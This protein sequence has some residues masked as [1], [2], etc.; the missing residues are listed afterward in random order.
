V[1]QPRKFRSLDEATVDIAR[2]LEKNGNSIHALLDR[3]REPREHIHHPDE[4][5]EY[6]NDTFQFFDRKIFLNQLQGHVRPTFESRGILFTE[7]AGKTITISGKVYCAKI[8]LNRRLFTEALRRFGRSFTQDHLFATLLHQMIHA[9]FIAACGLQNDGKD[10]DGR[11]KHEEHFG[12]IM[13]RIREISGPIKHLPIGF[14]N[15]L[16]VMDHGAKRIDNYPYVQSNTRQAIMHSAGVLHDRGRCTECARDIEPISDEK[17]NHWYKNKCLKAVDPDIF[18]V[19]FSSHM[20]GSKPMSN[21]GNKSDWVELVYAGKPFMLARKFL[22]NV[23]SFSKNFNEK[24][25]L[26][27]PMVD[28]KLFEAMMSFLIRKYY[29]PDPRDSRKTPRSPIIQVYSQ[30]SPKFLEHDIAVYKLGI[31]LNFEELKSYALSRLTSRDS[32]YE[33]PVEIVKGIYGN[34]TGPGKCEPDQILRDWAISFFTRYT[35]PNPGCKPI[36][37]SNWRKL[38]NNFV[39]RHFLKTSKSA[40]NIDFFQAEHELKKLPEALPALFTAA[41]MHQHPGAYQGTPYALPYHAAP[42]LPPPHDWT[43]PN[44]LPSLG[45]LTGEAIGGP[46]FDDSD[47]DEWPYFDHGLPS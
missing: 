3:A 26:D 24:R 1:S 33:N 42:P 6:L 47:E 13:A 4:L 36:E 15:N 9:Y 30:S 22:A 25:K 34:T 12:Y 2:H 32:T 5:D 19:D 37:T 21:C 44:P 29:E 43:S 14:G 31:C 23:P 7:D 20:F 8:V 39:F 28:N 18:E 11:L 41:R 38:N 17:L 10:P 40:V 16:P 46:Y 35:K 27:I 45:W